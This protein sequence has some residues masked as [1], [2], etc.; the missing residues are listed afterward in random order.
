MAS[1]KTLSSQ[2]QACIAKARELRL[3]VANDSLTALVDQGLPFEGPAAGVTLRIQWSNNFSGRLKQ[4]ALYPIALPLLL[5]LLLATP[6]SYV[7]HLR[8]VSKKKAELRQRIALLRDEPRS[9]DAPE[10]RRLEFLWVLHGIKEDECTFDER[11]QLLSDWIATLY[12]PGVAESL[13][14]RERTE[15]IA[16]RYSEANRPYYEGRRGP[17]FNFKPPLDALIEQLSTE[18]PP[19]DR[20]DTHRMQHR[21]PEVDM[22]DLDS[23]VN[24]LKDSYRQV[25]GLVCSVEGRFP[26]A[27]EAGIFVSS[28]ATTKILSFE[29]VDPPIFADKL[30]AKWVQHLM[31]NPITIGTPPS[32][33]EI[34]LRMQEK[35]PVYRKLFLNAIDPARAD[36]ASDDAVQLMWELFTN[37]TGKRKPDDNA[38]FVKLVLASGD[39]V[40]VG[41][42]ILADIRE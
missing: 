4:I 16:R 18:L 31:S 19:Y 27:W 34:V 25:F 14:M 37:C 9:A 28:V 39:L 21:R 8:Q 20:S 5:V 29:K 7:G 6:F 42:E 33:K 11:L 24:R 12:G 13:N 23:L 41:L 36:K 22:I 17:H 2:E 32:R 10:Q 1:A 38:N 35:F 26:N 15:D 40:S 3:K 30:N